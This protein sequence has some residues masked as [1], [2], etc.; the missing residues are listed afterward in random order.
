MVRSTQQI[1]PHLKHG[2]PG[3]RRRVDTLLVEIQ[4]NA[5]GVQLAEE[6]DEVL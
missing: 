2:L 1:P 3:R 4:V 5:F 6:R